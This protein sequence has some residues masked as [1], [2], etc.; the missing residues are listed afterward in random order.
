MLWKV[1]PGLRKFLVWLPGVR[2]EGVWDGFES[3][4]AGDGLGNELGWPPEWSR[5]A[6]LRLLGMRG[7]SYGSLESR[8][9]PV[10][11]RE[12]AGGGEGGGMASG[13]RQTGF[14]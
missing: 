3:E 9:S 10:R 12:T 6:P 14:K 2:L 5:H 1:Q 13:G 7:V 8:Q 11:N 4:V